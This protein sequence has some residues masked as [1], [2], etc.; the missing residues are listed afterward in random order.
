[1]NFWKEHT[2]LRILF[3]AGF[4]FAGLALVVYGWTLTGKLSGLGWMVVGVILL[5]A[6]LMI[7]NKPFE[8]GK[9]PRL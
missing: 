7:Y 5:L 1:M 3:I 8:G 6:A 2:S 4:F 9:G